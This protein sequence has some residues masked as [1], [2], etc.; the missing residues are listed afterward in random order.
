[1]L[2]TAV[3]GVG[4]ENDRGVEFR[5]LT[6]AEPSDAVM[7]SMA[8]SKRLTRARND[9]VLNV[10]VRSRVQHGQNATIGCLFVNVPDTS[11]IPLCI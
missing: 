2:R 1:M 8:S 3:Y 9:V 10:V 4:F 7:R 6:G 5:G 11:Q